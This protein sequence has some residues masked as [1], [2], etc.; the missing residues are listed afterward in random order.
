MSHASYRREQFSRTIW[1][2]ICHAARR[3]FKELMAWFDITV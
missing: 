1:R 2:D 3:V